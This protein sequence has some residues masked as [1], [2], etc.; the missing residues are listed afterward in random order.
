MAITSSLRLSILSPLGKKASPHSVR[1]HYVGVMSPDRYKS[2]LR[3]I[4]ERR[5]RTGF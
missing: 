2:V 1:R 5:L 4:A 3:H